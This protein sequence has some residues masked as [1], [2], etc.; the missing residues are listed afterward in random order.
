MP[1]AYHTANGKSVNASHRIYHFYNTN[2]L[3][4]RVFSTAPNMF[5]AN[6]NL[7][8]LA[9]PKP[10]NIRSANNRAKLIRNKIVALTGSMPRAYTL[11][12]N[13]YK[14]RF[15]KRRYKEFRNPGHKQ[16]L[17]F[18]KTL[19]NAIPVNQK[20]PIPRINRPGL[21]VNVPLYTNLSLHRRYIRERKPKNNTNMKQIVRNIIQKQRNILNSVSPSRRRRLSGERSASPRRPSLNYRAPSFV[22]RSGLRARAPSFVPR[23]GLS[24]RAPSFV[25]RSYFIQSKL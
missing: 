12:N 6:E 10:T 5:F 24:A 23:S 14:N 17:T 18:Y 9:L 1:N 7:V 20:N 4:K 16:Q 8:K 25:P 13:A 15:A 11:I 3:V 2:N 19:L 21:H 22:P